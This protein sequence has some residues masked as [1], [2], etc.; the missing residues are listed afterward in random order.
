MPIHEIGNY[1]YFVLVLLIHGNIDQNADLPKH[2]PGFQTRGHV[3]M[4][5]IV[6]SAHTHEH[7]VPG[8]VRCFAPE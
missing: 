2:Y 4:E 1:D 5:R 8:S 3:T 6:R 7:G